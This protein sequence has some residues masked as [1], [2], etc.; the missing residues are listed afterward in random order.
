M[1][2][3]ADAWVPKG[4]CDGR[5]LDGLG[6]ETIISQLVVGQLPPDRFLIILLLISW[7]LWL[8]LYLL[9]NQS[10]DSLVLRV[11]G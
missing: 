1:T 5:L 8:L 3:L 7:K 4:G 6:S 10:V 11:V 9:I 2:I